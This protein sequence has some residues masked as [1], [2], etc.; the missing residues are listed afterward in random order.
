[1]MELSELLFKIPAGTKI[2]VCDVN[3]GK[4]GIAGV[5][6]SLYHVGMGAPKM[7]AAAS[8]FDALF[9]NP[10]MFSFYKDDRNKAVYVEFGD[11]EAVCDGLSSKWVNLSKVHPSYRVLPFVV[12]DIL[13]GS[14]SELT[15]RF[16][17]LTRSEDLYTS[18]LN[19]FEFCD[20]YYFGS[21]KGRKVEQTEDLTESE[22]QAAF[23]SNLYQEAFPELHD[24]TRKSK[25]DTGADAAPAYASTSDTVSHSSSTKDEFIQKCIDGEFVIPVEWPEEMSRYMVSRDYLKTY[26]PTP[27][28][29]E[30]VTLV[31]KRLGRIQQRMAEGLTGADAIG[32]DAVNIMIVGKPGTGKTTLA[33]ALAAATGMPICSTVHT[34]HSD[35]DMYTGMTRIVDGHPEFVETDSLVMHEKGGIDVCEEINLSDPSVTMGGLGQKLEYPFIL[36]KNGYETVVRNPFNVVIATMNV[37]TNGSAQL[38]QALANR[39]NPVF[40]L[41][42]PTEETFVGILKKCSGAASKVCRW[43]YSAYSKCVEYLTSPD[44]GADYI[45]QNLS[46]RTCLSAISAIGDGVDPHRALVNSL[47][48]AVAVADLEIARQMQTDVIDCIRDLK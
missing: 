27:E 35:D 20:S 16:T 6:T 21:A 19:L 14:N 34:K 44:V 12:Q 4:V 13:Y 38:N 33:Y 36:K 31:T 11:A 41:D 2:A 17:D 23:R 30:V 22:I 18:A 48:G 39:F 43:V 15:E 25:Y 46:I 5:S 9:T 3:I 40:L 37:G 8:I 26:E 1:M 28:F 29:R 47:V 10:K 42:D 24:Y 45:T 32:H 7:S